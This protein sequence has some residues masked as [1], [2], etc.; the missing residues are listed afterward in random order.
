MKRPD[1]EKQKINGKAAVPESVVIPERSK[2][3]IK[4]DDL[5]QVHFPFERPYVCQENY[6]RSLV[7]AL[8]Y[9]QNALLESPTG[10]G[11]TLCLLSG[12][13]GFLQA[14][15]ENPSIFDDFD[16]QGNPVKHA[17]SSQPNSP[18]RQGEED[19]RPVRRSRGRKTT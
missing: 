4:V 7:K 10:T 12:T 11:K 16:E 6:V 18:D 15:I 14:Y 1:P 9:R 2:S 5:V 13:L 3:I 8:R 19:P 17:N